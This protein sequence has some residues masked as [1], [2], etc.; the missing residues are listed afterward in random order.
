[1]EERTTIN[2]PPPSPVVLTVGCKGSLLARCREAAAS[3]P[4]DLEA[5]DVLSLA[6]LA[7]SLRPLAVLVNADLYG[8]DPEEFDA[9]TRSVGARRILVEED[10]PVDCLAVRIAEAVG[11]SATARALD[12]GP[13]SRASGAPCSG[14]RWKA[15]KQARSA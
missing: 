10:E 8:F 15:V 3:I 11:A 5:G 1:M 9:L 14:I 12:A 4:I 6:W 7:T 2:T 13:P